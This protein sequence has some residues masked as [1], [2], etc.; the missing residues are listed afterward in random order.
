MMKN[1]NTKSTA[2]NVNTTTPSKKTTA[3]AKKIT[4]SSIFTD[5]IWVYF[6]TNLATR[7][8]KEYWNV[9]K[10]F[11]KCVGHDPYELSLDDAKK[12]YEDL[13]N[14]IQ[15]EKLSYSTAV[16]RYSVMRSMC[17]F[18][19]NYRISHGEQ[20]T[21]Y[22]KEFSIPEQDKIFKSRDLP[23]LTVIDKVLKKALECD[24]YKAFTIF[25][26]S[27]KLGLTNSEICNLKFE[28]IAIVDEE[29]LAIELTASKGATRILSLDKDISEILD[30][31]INIYQVSSGY[32]FL[33]NRKNPIKMRDTE[34]LLLKYIDMLNEQGEEIKPF[35]MQSLRHVALT[36]M[37]SGGAT[38][39]AVA[40][41]TGITT[42]WMNRY[43]KVVKK[44][45]VDN[46]NHL[47]VLS[48]K[49]NL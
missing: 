35:T 15:K 25:S 2:A 22:F 45:E 37:L 39:E 24:D 14:K 27:L 30:K 33:N 13:I 12:F 11:T 16:M 36:A 5:K 41:F 28:N 10:Y 23:S 43:E 31:Y 49:S 21:N 47:S 44:Y 40:K 46:T 19:E 4:I 26:L 17:D 20:Y 29:N 9:V 8:R 7:T 1:N 32:L 3:T 18:I 38:K 42:K 6:E 48:I 34:R